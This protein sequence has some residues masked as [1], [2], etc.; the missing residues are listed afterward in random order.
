MNWLRNFVRPK[1]Q[2]LVG[3]RKEVPENLWHKC[4]E[5]GQMIFH[6]ELKKMLHVC[7]HCGHHMRLDGRSRLNLLFDKNSYEIIDTPKV[8][9]DPLKFKDIKRYSERL[10]QARVNTNSKEA[11]CIAVGTMGGNNVVIAVFD[12]NF[13]G[14]SMGV[15]VG[16]GFVTA[17]RMAVSRHLP[18][19]VVPSSGGAR[20]QEGIHSLMQMARTTIAV[21]EVKEAGLPY[22]V[23]LTDP[24]TGGVTA[25]FAMLGDIAIA[26]PG[27]VIGFAGQ[28]VIKQT[29]RE[30]L[31]EGFQ[32]AEY[33]LE[34][35]MVDMVVPRNSL[36]DTLIRVIELLM[37]KNNNSGRYFQKTKS[38]NSPGGSWG[39]EASDDKPFGASS[40]STKL[41]PPKADVFHEVRPNSSIVKAE[42]EKNY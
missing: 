17:A 6:R 19:V 23:V 10:K 16:E 35:G 8:A 24:T 22:I 9:D 33:L 1:I 27:S 30:T 29:I 7:Q 11:L 41:D 15:A 40:S 39:D 2:K 21:E 4:V 18:L 14:G 13:L 31:P 25:S 12:F 28:R 36:R 32:R 20:M 34:H 38:A 5:C 26:E 3:A 42:N 37:N